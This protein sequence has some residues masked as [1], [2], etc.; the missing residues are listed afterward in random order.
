MKIEEL[1]SEMA[2]EVV[3]LDHNYSN[4]N[5]KVNIVVDT[6]TKDVELHSSLLTKIEAK[7]TFVSQIFAKLEELL[8]SLNEL[9]TKLGSSL[10]SSISQDFFS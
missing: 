2:K 4:L 7:S 1:H 10:L 8:G 3:K 6:V 9:L 5:T